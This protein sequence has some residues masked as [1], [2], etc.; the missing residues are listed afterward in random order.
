MSEKLEKEEQYLFEKGIKPAWCI[1]IEQ[2][3]KHYRDYPYQFTFT[4]VNSVVLFQNQQKLLDFKKELVG[5]TD[6]KGKEHWEFSASTLGKALGY[7]PKAVSYF[8]SDE[9]DEFVQGKHPFTKLYV[10]Y[11]GLHFVTK[12]EYV[13]EDIEWLRIHMPLPLELQDNIFVEVVFKEN[14]TPVPSFRKQTLYEQIPYSFFIEKIYPHFHTKDIHT[15]NNL[16]KEKQKN[17]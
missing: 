3:E 11:A 15:M 9:H 5:F 17:S 10:N 7:P 8:C 4:E 16:L 1:S 13:Q 6:E 2:A 12:A 14:Q